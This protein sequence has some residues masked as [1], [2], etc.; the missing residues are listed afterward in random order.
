MPW[1]IKPKG[2]QFCVVK[3]DS[4]EEV[5]CHDAKQEATD[6]MR[7]LYAN[8]S[9]EISDALAVLDKEAA[10]E[11]EDKHC[12]PYSWRPYLGA[13]SFRELDEVRGTQEKARAIREVNYQF[14]ELMDNIIN[15]EEIEDKPAALNNLVSEYQDRLS[16]AKGPNFATLLKE[17]LWP[18]E[19]LEESLI[20]AAIKRENGL[21]F[22]ARDY[23]YAP[24]P[25]KPAT[26]GLRLTETPGKVSLKQLQRIALLLT[27]EKAA[28][29][30]SAALNAV[31]RRVRA[32]F[33]KLGVPDSQLPP[34]V[35][36]GVV[37]ARIKEA[38]PTPTNS[39]SVWKDAST[40]KY[41]WMA[42]YS[43]NFRDNDFP[44]E[45]ISEK[46]H[47]A[48]TYLANEGILPMPELWHWHT[49]GT[50]WGI[51]K[52][53]DFVDG[54]AVAIG[55]VDAGFENHAEILSQRTDLGVSHG[56]LRK[57]IQR[58]PADPSCINFHITYEISDLPLAKAANKHTGFFVIKE[59]DEMPFT[60]ERREYL[61]QLG[62]GEEN[63]A[64]MESTLFGTSKALI[65][66]GVESK[67]AD[68]PA[69][70]AA[71]AA[72]AANDA[73]VTR[74]EVAQVLSD[75]IGPIVV[76]NQNLETANAELTKGILLLSE[77]LGG[78][79]AQLKELT[80]AD[81][82]K[83]SK[84]ATTTPAASLSEMMT[85]AL[86]KS[87]QVPSTSTL[88]KSGPTQAEIPVQQ[89]TPSGFLNTVIAKSHAAPAAAQ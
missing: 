62:Y 6:H 75:I 87:N 12:E 89:V 60:P 85:A 70:E 13:T 14:R 82:T 18:S 32:E 25:A 23:A 15:D 77:R 17:T 68:A 56:M 72:E 8:E 54:F 73:P 28:G 58:D 88:I 7:A 69:D 35:R 44:P 84:A 10:E 55:D 33:R 16:T 79:E 36:E 5:S 64:Q 2:N 53:L 39:F 71:P 31:K 67:E 80:V 59:Q 24:D 47:K 74:A 19:P 49:P 9:K 3:K 20:K 51:T 57:H 81:A 4:G 22:P 26:W 29:I 61:K 38:T 66:A 21:D 42:V 76:H 11:T 1:E 34:S 41:H 86:N 65:Q 78:V 50:R 83:I 27:N 30:P 63:I 52:Q 43:N 40:G 45:I 48:F 37:V 46:S